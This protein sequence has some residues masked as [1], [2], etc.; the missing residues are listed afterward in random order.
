[1][2]YTVTSG[3]FAQPEGTVL[4]EEQLGTCNIAALL[5][6]GHLTLNDMP[7]APADAS[8][9]GT[10]PPPPEEQDRP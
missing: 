2:N 10:S 7:E 5:A 1:M 8:D 6:G 9:E 3:N 4:S